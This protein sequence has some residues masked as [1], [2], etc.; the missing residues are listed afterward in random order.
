MSNYAL[1]LVIGTS[2]CLSGCNSAQTTPQAASTSALA[3][4]DA[5]DPIKVL[6]A[7]DTSLQA[8]KSFSCDVELTARVQA[9]GMDNKVVSAHTIKIEKPNRWA[10]VHQS[11][12]I[13]GT[14]IS[15][16]EQVVNY[17]PA[18]QRYTV[19]ETSADDAQ[20]PDGMGVYQTMGLMGAA[21][22][23]QFFL[24]GGFAE[25]LLN[26]VTDSEFLGTES[27]DGTECH[28]YRYVQGEQM[29]WDLWVEIGE[30]VLVRRF[31]ML[32]DGDSPQEAM[33]ISVDIA[34]N[35]WKPAEEF[36]ED[37]FAFVPPA[38]ATKVDNLIE[39][40]GRRQEPPPH[41]LLGM[42]A[43][44]FAIMH[45]DG[46]EVALEAILGEK[47]V[48]L[49]FWATWCG[50]CTA[51]LPGVAKVAAEFEGED[52]A[53]FAVN[54]RESADEVRAFLEEEDL[55]LE[56]LLDSDGDVGDLYA[57]QGIPT[58]AIIG[59]D[60]RIQ[61]VHVGYAPGLEEKLKS[62]ISQLLAGEELAA[63]TVEDA[64]TRETEAAADRS[65]G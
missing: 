54:Q 36:S 64:E 53:V 31:A 55:D 10:I 19:E 11:G 20:G 46:E 45:L 5:K 57:V 14:S 61:V 13:G 3:D 12:M 24:E 26:G 56:V 29:Q 4:E 16:G 1:L 7:F 9:Q 39:G 49:D 35:N 34:L 23:P 18:L 44:T 8:I 42:Q 32:P 47:V 58:T 6:E 27:I 37:A 33:S 48:V 50:P 2:L 22:F 59:K 21:A 60:K 51:A 63:E 65:G 41:P 62:E 25:W 30:H 38:D 43:P 40:L 52:V 28:H 15:D 17:L